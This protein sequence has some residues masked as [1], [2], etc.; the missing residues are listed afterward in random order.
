[1]NPLLI[2]LK[3][4]SCQGDLDPNTAV[5]GVIECKFC[6]NKFTLPKSE[7]NN[8]IL[9]SLRDAERELDRGHFEEAFQTYQRVSQESENEPEAYFGM[10]IANAKVQYLNSLREDEET[11]E[12]KKCLQPICYDIIDKKFTDDRNYKKAL[13]L[14]TPDQ[15]KVYIEKGKEID[16]IR[17]KFNELKSSGVSYDCFICTKV[18]EIDNKNRHTEDC[19]DAEQLYS[20]IKE[21]GYNPFFSE[22][23]L[24]KGLGVDYEAYILYALYS[25]PCMIIV[26]N[27]ESYLRTPWVQNEYTRFLQMIKNEEKHLNSITF[28]FKNGHIIEKL[29]GVSGKIQGVAIDSYGAKDQIIDFVS[30]FS[31][32]RNRIP[33]I[34][35]KEYGKISAAKKN[36]IEQQIKKRELK[37]EKR[38]VVTASDQANFDTIQNFLDQSDFETARSMAKKLIQQN[39]KLSEAYWFLW[40]ADAE[41]KDTDEFVAKKKK[42]NSFD[43]FEKA[44]STESDASKRKVYYDALYKRVKEHKFLNEYE[45]YITLPESDPKKIEELSELMYNVALDSKDDKTFKIVIKTVT[46]TDKYINMNKEFLNKVPSMREFCYSNILDVDKADSE[47]LYENFAIKNLENKK[48]LSEFLKDESNFKTLEKDVYSYG[49][50]EYATDIIFM[51]VIDLVRKE[52]D[53][54]AGK[55]FDFVLKMIP[56]NK[57]ELFVKY[58]QEFIDNLL[59]LAGKKRKP[60][61]D[62]AA[63]YNELLLQTDKHNYDACFNRFL[64]KHRIGNLLELVQFLDFMKQDEEY[65][66]AITQFNEVHPEQRKN[67]KYVLLLKAIESYVPLLSNPDEKDDAFL[68]LYPTKEEIYDYAEEIKNEIVLYKQRERDKAS[69][70]RKKEIASLKSKISELYKKFCEEHKLSNEDEVFKIR[71]NV[72][73]DPILVEI[74][75]LA[76]KLD[77][78][79]VK[80]E[81]K[82]VDKIINEQARRAHRNSRSVVIKIFSVF[83]IIIS[84]AVSLAFFFFP[85][86]GFLGYNNA[87]LIASIGI[88]HSN[89]FLICFM[90]I[91]VAMIIV[92]IACLVGGDYGIDIASLVLSIFTLCIGVGIIGLTYTYKFKNTTVYSDNQIVA[93]FKL[94]DGSYTLNSLC[95]LKEFN[96]ELVLPEIYNHLPVTVVGKKFNR[97]IRTKNINK[98]TVPGSYTTIDE[99]A[100]CGNGKI[101]EIVISDNVTTVGKLAFYKCKNLTTLTIGN[102]IS[103]FPFREEKLFAGEYTYMFKK[104]KHLTTIYFGDGLTEID[105]R[106]FENNPS[107]NEIHFGKN[108]KY[109]KDRAF[110]KCTN[111]KEV[112]FSGKI[113]IGVSAFAE[114][115]VEKI[116]FIDLT[117]DEKDTSNQKTEEEMTAEEKAFAELPIIG[118]SAFANCVNLTEVTLGNGVD[119]IGKLAFYSCSNLTTVDFSKCN[120]LTSIGSQAFSKCSSLTAANLKKCT[121]LKTIGSAAFDSCS[122]L[123]EL[124][125]N[126]ELETISDN[127]FEGTTSLQSVTITAKVTTVGNDSFKNS[128]I[129]YA[130][131]LVTKGWRNGKSWLGSGNIDSYFNSDPATLAEKLKNCIGW[132]R[133]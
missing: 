48:D 123:S 128:G 72:S 14:A 114:S 76:L 107:L 67:N 47:A 80:E 55:I 31:E 119:K 110:Y 21:A 53:E 105:E 46:N 78:L 25:S 59:G 23:V 24:K 66:A 2:Q 16:D 32:A 79:S 112:E 18:S 93:K 104:C 63:S 10:A 11:G 71:K 125:F 44:I 28:A 83:F 130:K 62:M 84:F 39:P 89:F 49:F 57:D 86:V 41:T 74:R 7:S 3:C 50:N 88:F 51:Q 131:F 68:N 42:I 60:N 26:C 96:G 116:L 69:D 9:E 122:S 19:Y 75:E 102:G 73:K 98:L 52:N 113:K 106:A 35:R 12:P 94:N 8:E 4:K 87:F 13:E 5:G 126:D 45:E 82:K 132:Y 108:I 22:K 36:V 38:G 56:K 1:M 129:T 58:L 124:V 99:K 90:L 61:F 15:K 33:D 34:N 65:L 97:G 121:S 127:A 117:E 109:I 54:Q 95:T 101:L 81:L 115:G 92:N 64:I 17:K 133:Y 70:K 37:I 118:E 120:N 20:S 85:I 111:L 29:P 40:L 77:K 43:N 91:G 103:S 100:F 27:D 30:R 6:G